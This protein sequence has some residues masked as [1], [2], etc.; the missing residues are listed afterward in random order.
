[1]F[2]SPVLSLKDILGEA[3]IDRVIEACDYFGI[4]DKSDAIKTAEEKIDFYPKPLQEKNDE[5]LKDIGKRVISPIGKTT[6]GAA[7]DSFNKATNLNAAPVCGFGGMRIGEDGRL[8]LIS[9]SEHYHAPLGHGFNGYKLIENA[10]KLGISNAAHNN[11]RGYITRLLETELVKTAGG[12]IDRVINLETGSVA[13][14]A[15]I[16]MMLSRFYRLDKT[17][18]AP[19]YSGRIP[20]FFV[21]ADANGTGEA[22]YHG[23]TITAQT[24]RGMWPEISDKI[25]SDGIYKTV[26]VK[27]ND[28]DDFKDKTVMYNS[29]KYKTAGFIHEIVLM[30][31]G[32]ILLTKDYLKAAYELCEKYDTPVMADEIQSCMWYKG[33]YLH[34]LYGLKPD[35][36]I[37]GKGFPGGQYPASRVLTN[38]KMDTL[39][40]FGALV[41]NGQ[42]ELA[43]LTYL[44]TMIF[45]MA[46]GDIIEKL[47][48]YFEASLRKLHD[49]FPD[50]IT[51]I[52]GKGHCAAI[53]FESVEKAI[54]FTGIL[55]SMCVDISA[56]VYKANCPPAALLKIP[57]I[58]SEKTVDFLTDKM[59][60]ALTEN[61]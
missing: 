55:N 51:R 36:V 34:K 43:S 5:M 52:E 35:F 39:N 6:M 50:K 7:T 25:E 22:N 26:P 14:E 29:G 18:E 10:K 31:Y 61:N 17:Y 46:N 41:T 23:T 37:L 1:M 19:V 27:I 42:E 33:M 24:L 58:A 20:V 32:G 40:Q 16:K 44:I 56:Q 48:N 53:H 60:A 3:Y 4:S 8:Y 28:I 12:G 11:T 38:A 45:A 15:A 21:M 54:N 57:L 59:R 47:G 9:K 2:N 49:E 13:C 30:N